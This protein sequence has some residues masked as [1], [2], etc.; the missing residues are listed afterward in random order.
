MLRWRNGPIIV[1]SGLLGLLWSSVVTAEECLKYHS[2]TSEIAAFTNQNGDQLEF[3][4]H[5]GTSHI[6]YDDLLE[7][8]TLRVELNGDDVTAVFVDQDGQLKHIIEIP[9]LESEA[10]LRFVGEFKGDDVKVK[11]YGCADTPLRW[12]IISLIKK[13]IEA[14]AFSGANKLTPEQAEAWRKKR[15]QRHSR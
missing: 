3:F 9:K 10:E 4:P 14:S 11:R 6:R 7:K 12:Q 13:P 1:I 2:S 8:E 5:G 15:N